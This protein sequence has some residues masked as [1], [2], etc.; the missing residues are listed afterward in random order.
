MRIECLLLQGSLQPLAEN[1]AGVFPMFSPGA[2]KKQRAPRDTPPHYPSSAYAASRT[3]GFTQV[4]H[5]LA[6]VANTILSPHPT[7]IYTP[8]KRC[9]LQV[10]IFLGLA[11]CSEAAKQGTPRDAKI[12]YRALDSVSYASINLEHFR[13]QWSESKMVS[14]CGCQGGGGMGEGRIGSLAL[15]DANYDI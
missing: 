8:V 5:V 6:F 12:T 10:P 9:Y 15:S 11:L 7:H 3:L 13:R 2:V 4:I 14:Q 1:P